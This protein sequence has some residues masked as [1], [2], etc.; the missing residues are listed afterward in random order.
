[1]QKPKLNRVNPKLIGY[2][3][4]LSYFRVLTSS[5]SG[6]YCAK[7]SNAKNGTIWSKL[8]KNNMKLEESCIGVTKSKELM[9]KSNKLYTTYFQSYGQDSCSGVFFNHPTQIE[10]YFY[11]PF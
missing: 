7:F 11:S 10:K 6:S 1:M 3:S 2:Y 9:E 8:F 5:A 4:Y